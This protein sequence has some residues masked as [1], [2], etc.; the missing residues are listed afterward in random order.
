MF[1]SGSLFHE[2]LDPKWLTFI[3]AFTQNYRPLEIIV[4]D[5][6][7]TDNTKS[8]INQIQKKYNNA[9]D[10][11]KIDYI[12]QNNHGVSDARNNGI[13]HSKGEYICFLDS[14]DI[15]YPEKISE[16]FKLLNDSI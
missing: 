15:Y 5:D 9:L 1:Q 16:Q 14:D 11:L 4:I 2:H 12:F 13:S 10:N 3:L 6:G 8:I 7:S